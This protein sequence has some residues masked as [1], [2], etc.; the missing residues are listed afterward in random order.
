MDAT[1]SVQV[2]S[3][4]DDTPVHVVS[5]T[6]SVFTAETIAVTIALTDSNG[7]VADTVFLVTL[8]QVNCAAGTARDSSGARVCVD[9]FR[10]QE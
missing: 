2:P 1:I 8:A 10:A 9:T 3:H 6:Y 7:A 4:T 5:V